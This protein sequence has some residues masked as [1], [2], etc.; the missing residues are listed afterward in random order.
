MVAALVLVGTSIINVIVGHLHIEGENPLAEVF[1]ALT[2]FT[3]FSYLMSLHQ[4]GVEEER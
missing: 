2:L 1:L 4:G 3:F